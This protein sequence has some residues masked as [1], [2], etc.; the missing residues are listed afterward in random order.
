MS[1]V[2][3]L[4]TKVSAWCWLTGYLRVPYGTRALRLRGSFCFPAALPI[5]VKHSSKNNLLTETLT[6]TLRGPAFSVT[7]STFFENAYGDTYGYLAEPS[8]FAYGAQNVLARLPK[9]VKHYLLSK[10]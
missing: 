1:H 8:T 9:S 4:V 10:P 3:N 2:K 5:S 6:D 7:G